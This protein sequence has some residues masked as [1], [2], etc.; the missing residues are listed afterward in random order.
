MTSRN[1][2]ILAMMM[3]HFMGHGYAD[4]SFSY[5]CGGGNNPATHRNQ[6]NYTLAIEGHSNAKRRAKI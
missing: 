4:E 3:P 6:R 5:H 1:R 2:L